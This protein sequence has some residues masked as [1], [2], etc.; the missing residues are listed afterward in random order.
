[1]TLGDEFGERQHAPAVAPRAVGVEP[2]AVLEQAGE[3]A[4]VDHAWTVEGGRARRVSG[5]YPFTGVD[6]LYTLLRGETVFASA[7]RS[8]S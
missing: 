4:E 7:G 2:V 1:M 6:V 5:D 3:G 8:T